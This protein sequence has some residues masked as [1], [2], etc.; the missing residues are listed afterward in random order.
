M[1]WYTSALRLMNN[2]DYRDKEPPKLFLDDV[3]SSYFEGTHNEL[4]AF[5][6]NRDGK[7]GKRQIVIGLLCDEEGVALS[8]EVFEGNTSD[9]KTFLPQVRKSAERF[10][11]R[12]VTFV[13][14]RGM[15][16]SPQ[17][18]QLGEG[19]H[20]ITAITKP[21][22]ESLLRAGV[23]QMELFDQLRSGN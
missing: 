18:E 11:V 3:T 15:I 1:N 23:I 9:A 2:P 10:G 14:D 16:K 20:Y 12:E 22:I 19:L 7:R 8:I 4:A 17:I 6:Y 5:G 13:G 21:Q